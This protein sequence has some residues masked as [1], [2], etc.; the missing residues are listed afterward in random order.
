MGKH[1]SRRES[2]R[3]GKHVSRRGVRGAGAGAAHASIL[4]RLFVGRSLILKKFLGSRMAWPV[5]SKVSGMFFSGRKLSCS[6]VME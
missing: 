2:R 3:E 6:S 4:E 1:V 5:G